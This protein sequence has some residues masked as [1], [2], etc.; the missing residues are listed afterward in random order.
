MQHKHQCMHPVFAC[1]AKTA[2]HGF[3]FGNEEAGKEAER[4]INA[5][6]D[7]AWRHPEQ[8]AK[9]QEYG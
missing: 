9:A 4:R 7:K 6:G 5:G 1:A 3:I 2:M 8:P